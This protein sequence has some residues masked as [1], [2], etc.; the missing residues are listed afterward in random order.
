MAAQKPEFSIDQ[1]RQIAHELYGFDGAGKPLP[2]YYD[3]NFLLEDPAGSRRVLKISNTMDDFAAVD[4]QNGTLQCAAASRQFE[5]ARLY[6]TRDDDP[7][8]TVKGRNGARHHV[9]LLSYVA[10]TPWSA[11]AP[12][13]RRLRLDLGRVTGELTRALEGFAH[14]AM[15]RFREWDLKHSLRLERYVRDIGDPRRRRLIESILERFADHI[16]PRLEGLPC[17]VVHGDVNNDNV[18]VR[19]DRVVGLID[20]GD[21]TYT[22]NVFELAIA[23]AYAM[24]GAED[25]SAAADDVLQ[26]YL[27]V[28]PLQQRER[29]LVFDLARTRLAASVTFAA[30][31]SRL[32]PSNTYVATNTVAGWRVLEML[33]G[34]ETQVEVAS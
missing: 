5:V 11:S 26:G 31:Y 23:V 18:L 16:E 32:D 19:G 21:V 27:S 8:A 30:H 34:D 6:P 22:A 25:P 2:S 20:F 15:Q 7:I 13:S 10:G 1:A 9:R 4:L 24:L 29:D 3:Q 12:Y 14:P 28:R 17:G 33:E